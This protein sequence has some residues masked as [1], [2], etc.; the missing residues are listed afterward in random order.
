MRGMVGF[1]IFLF[2]AYLFGP[3]VV[4]GITAFNSPSYPQAYPFEFF[5]LDW[6]VKLWNDRGWRA[7][8]IPSSS[9]S[10]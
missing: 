10:A 7:S 8:P 6:F 2:F 1:Y 4:M 3:L 5:T 9:A